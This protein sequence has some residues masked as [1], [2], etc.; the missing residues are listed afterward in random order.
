MTQETSKRNTTRWAIYLLIVLLFLL[1]VCCLGSWLLLRQLELNPFAPSGN[2]GIVLE[3]AYTPDKD[4]LFAELI[5][6]FNRSRPQTPQGERITV[7]GSSLEADEMITAALEGRFQAISPDS[8][9]WLDQM[10]SAHRQKRGESRAPLV[11]DATRYAT[12]P[13][14]IAMWENVAVEMGAGER[15]IGWHDLLARARR[16]PDFRWSHPATSSASGLLSTLAMFYAGAAKIRGLTQEDALAQETLDYVSALEQT[17]RYYGEGEQAIIQRALEEGPDFLDAFVVQEQLVVH[18]NQR[19]RQNKLLAVY[20]IEGTLWKDHPLALLEHPTLTD[21]QRQAYQ[22]FQEFLLS[23]E[24]QSFVLEQ[25]YRPADLSIPL[26]GP[27]SPLTAE[28]GV[29]PLEPKT[30]LQIPSPAV[31]DIVRQVWY[32]TKRKTN[33]YLV[34]DIS[35]SMEGEKLAQ[36]KEALRVFVAQIKGDQERV[37][38]LTF[39]SDVEEEVPLGTL[40]TNRSPL[41]QGIEDLEARGNTALLDGVYRAYVK[42][43]DLDDAERINAIVVMT[44]GRENQSGMRLPELQRRIEIG[45][46]QGLPVVIFCIAYGDDADLETLEEIAEVSGGQAR[47]GDLETIEELYKILSTYF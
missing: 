34:V 4:T 32:Y 19:Q 14:V 42:L 9:I 47:R 33:V 7:Q 13:I 45:N 16:D 43:Q 11:G 23:P 5:E 36:A 26:D 10:E 41:N 35:G 44:D 29:N 15:A 28:H 20:P 3:V 12:S 40:E 30:T 6:R 2:R 18:Y 24:I 38:L 22:A 8:S 21:G 27:G 1:P 25:G 31:I 46:Q 17:V 39:A 37:G